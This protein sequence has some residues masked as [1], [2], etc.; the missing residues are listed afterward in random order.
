M[1]KYLKPE[2]VRA[3]SL[4]Y[5]ITVLNALMNIQRL[6]PTIMESHRYEAWYALEAAIMGLDAM[7]APYYHEEYTGKQK[8]LKEKIKK[9]RDKYNKQEYMEALADWVQLIVQRFGQVNILPAIRVTQTAE[10]TTKIK[11]GK[12]SEKDVY[13][14][15]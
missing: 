9:A 6:I 3:E 15:D 12:D 11:P 10:P 8:A 5:E 13:K 2:D 1:K 7:V 4:T 14:E